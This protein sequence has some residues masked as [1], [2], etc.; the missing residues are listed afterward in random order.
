L[1]AYLE[2][3]LPAY[4]RPK[5]LRLRKRLDMTSTFKQRKIDLVAE[6][7]DLQRS[8]DPLY[9]EDSRLGAF[10]PL[11]AALR[12]RIVSGDVHL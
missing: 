10:V 6:G 3:H 4:A 8:A 5:F 12:E 1:H 7:F 9:Y 11:D 2:R